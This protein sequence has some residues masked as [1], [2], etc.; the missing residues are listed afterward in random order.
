VCLLA[1]A[2]FVNAH[3]ALARA[4]S[5]SVT[6]SLALTLVLVC[7][8]PYICHTDIGV[9][10][11]HPTPLAFPESAVSQDDGKEMRVDSMLKRKIGFESEREEQ[12]AK[13]SMVTRRNKKESTTCDFEGL[14][15]TSVCMCLHVYVRVHVHVRVCT[16]AGAGTCAETGAGACTCI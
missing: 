3:D 4:L 13:G 2:R 12:E 1:P 10:R 15:Y 8:S 9:R 14:A 7:L 6:H 11:L 16:F 5:F